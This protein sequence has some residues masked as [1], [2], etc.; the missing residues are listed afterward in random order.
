MPPGMINTFDLPAAAMKDMAAVPPR[1]VSYVAPPNARGDQVLQPRNENGVKVF[2]IEASVIR[3]NILPDVAVEAYAYNR[4][5][6]G[7]RLQLTEGDQVRINFHNAL[8]ESTTVHWH[9]LIVPNEMDGPA[10]IAQQPVPPGGSYKYEF[11]VGQS[12]TYFY[13]S[14]DHPDRQ[15]ALGLYGALLGRGLIKPQ[16]QSHGGDFCESQIG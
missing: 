16:P 15:Q 7:P 11:T 8:P 3:W 2:D 10:K 5:V 9:G 6:P 12:G 4:Q 14:H 13:H 1:E